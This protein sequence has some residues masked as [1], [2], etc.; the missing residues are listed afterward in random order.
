MS[1][2]AK[3][4]ALMAD[5]NNLE[6]ALDTPDTRIRQVIEFRLAEQRLELHR[7]ESA[8]RRARPQ[9]PLPEGLR[10]RKSP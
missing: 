4:A 3:I 8:H 6:S 7:L 1:L 10:P 2:L 9:S 5:I